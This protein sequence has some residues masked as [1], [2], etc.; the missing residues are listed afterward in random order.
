MFPVEYRYE[1]QS[2]G[3]RMMR[4]KSVGR[5]IVVET[6]GDVEESESLF[7]ALFKLFFSAIARHVLPPG[8][9]VA[10]PYQTRLR[11]SKAR[12]HSSRVERLDKQFPIQ[13]SLLLITSLLITEN[14]K[15]LSLLPVIRALEYIHPVALT[16]F[17]QPS[18]SKCLSYHSSASKSSITLQSSVTR[19]ILRSPLNV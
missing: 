10:Q 18:L 14:Q 4:G 13:F 5:G 2:T 12:L 7:P 11:E 9:T 19:I 16:T 8:Y 6:W 15:V 1:S 17:L 3:R